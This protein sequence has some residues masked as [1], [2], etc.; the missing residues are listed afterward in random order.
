MS[1]IWIM[2]IGWLAL[3]SV[4]APE[5]LAAEN[6]IMRYSESADAV[7]LNPLDLHMDVDTRI[8][9]LLFSTLITFDV[10]NKPQPMLLESLEPEIS[11]DNRSFIFALRQGVMWH[12]YR[13]NERKVGPQE[14][15]A[16][17]VFFTANIIRDRRSQTTVD[18]NIFSSVDT[19]DKYTVRFATRKSEEL[20]AVQ[21]ALFFPIIPKHVF[22][23]GTEYLVTSETEDFGRK[24]APGTGPYY[25][26]SRSLEKIQMNRNPQYFKGQAPLSDPTQ[27]P[28]DAIVMHIDK[29]HN[30]AVAQLLTEARHL[31]PLVPPMKYTELRSNQN[32]NVLP[33]NPRAIMYFAYNNNHRFLKDRNVRLALTYATDRKRMLAQIYGT[34][35]AQEIKLNILSGPFPSGEGDPDIQPLEYNPDKA[36]EL[37]KDAGFTQEGSQL[38]STA[39]GVK[40]P[41]VLVLTTFNAGEDKERICEFYKNDLGKIGVKVDINAVSNQRLNEDV[42]LERN[43]DVAL[44]HYSFPPSTDIVRDLFSK[45][46]LRRGG[47]NVT[48]YTN[49]EIE[50]ILKENQ[51]ADAE[52][53]DQNQKRLHALIYDDCPGTFLFST[54]NYA[55]YRVDRLGGVEIHPFRFFAYISDWYYIKGEETEDLFGQ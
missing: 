34:A 26:T 20:P 49:D 52:R 29:D 18:L 3:Q 50:A 37:L 22:A 5:L 43:F 10:F 51:S 36:L 17:D 40:E 27:A 16:E 1:K 54:Q 23:E 48:G 31:I 8:S 11:P 7:T 46:S 2:L 4:S 55:A 13:L 12:P 25:L 47:N 44:L 42:T 41:F 38:F 6:V 14:F 15:T 9:D 35:V 45:S 53:R 21:S 19:V 30:A 24:F 32:V 28:I 33:Y 39:G